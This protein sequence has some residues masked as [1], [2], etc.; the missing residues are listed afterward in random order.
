MVISKVSSEENMK[1]I[2][3]CGGSGIRLQNSISFI[4]KAMAMIGHRPMVWHIMKIFA[5]YGHKEF[6][7]ALGKNSE[8]IRDYFLNYSKY[9]NDITLRLG[10]GQPK[11]RTQHQEQDWEVTLVETGSEANTGARIS[12]CES[13]VKGK[14]FL[15]SYAD[16][17][18]DVDIKMLVG[19]HDVSGKVATVT[20]VLPPFRYGEFIIE[21]NKLVGYQ[22]ISLLKSF[23][24]WVN[25]GFM[26]FE[27][28]IF[29]FLSPYNECTLE[30]EIFSKLVSKKQMNIYTHEGFWQCLD[31]DREYKYLNR[32]CENNSEYWLYKIDR[33]K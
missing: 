19:S 1:V 8:L 33:K 4:P 21:N 32:L 9:V 28:E 29:K 11:F 15:V 27:P 7:L 24:G 3:L 31:N 26:V 6:V 16:C 23:R 5:N 18:A 12:R 10:S 14:R 2:I 22:N 30:E 25:G 20:G 13:Y 17:L